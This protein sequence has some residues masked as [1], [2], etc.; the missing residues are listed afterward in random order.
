MDREAALSEPLGWFRPTPDTD[1]A[2]GEGAEVHR[3][4]RQYV[5]QKVRS[6]G[7]PSRKQS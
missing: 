2:A 7:V 3:Q 4:V 5:Q 6:T 1:F